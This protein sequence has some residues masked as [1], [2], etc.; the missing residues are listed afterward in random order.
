MTRES[1]HVIDSS[2]REIPFRH[3]SNNILPLDQCQHHSSQARS[4]NPAHIVIPRPSSVLRKRATIARNVAQVVEVADIACRVVSGLERIGSLAVEAGLRAES[5]IFVH[6][7]ATIIGIEPER[8]VVVTDEAT[9]CEFAF[10]GDAVCIAESCADSPASTLLQ[11][12][13]A[14][15]GEYLGVDRGAGSRAGSG[16]ISC[17]VAGSRS[18]E[19]N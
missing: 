19:G 3:I 1:S 16:K 12:G 18:L 7:L 9:R 14:G 8:K 13:R 4:N 15:R 10:E 11:C 5:R 17:V 6:G 2:L